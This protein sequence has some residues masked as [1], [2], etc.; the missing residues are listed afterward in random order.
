M[1][2]AII[3]FFLFVIVLLSSL[4]YF[5]LRNRVDSY[6]DSVMRTIPRSEDDDDVDKDLQKIYEEMNSSSLSGASGSGRQKER[7]LSCPLTLNKFSSTIF[8]SIACLEDPEII[9][10]VV[11]LFISA[12]YSH[13]LAVGIYYQGDKLDICNHPELQPYSSQIQAHYVPFENAKGPC[14]ARRQIESFMYRKQDLFLQIDS[15]SR[16]ARGWDVI[17]IEELLKCKNPIM[18]ILSAYPEV[19]DTEAYLL[20]TAPRSPVDAQSRS[21]TDSDMIVPKWSMMPT[22]QKC[23]GFDQGTEMPMFMSQVFF[24]RPSTPVPQLCWSGCFSFTTREV[25][26]KVPYLTGVPFAFFGEE[27]IMFARYIS[28]GCSVLTPT[29]LPLLTRFNRYGRRSFK[30][31]LHLSNNRVLHESSTKKLHKVIGGRGTNGLGDYGDGPNSLGHD[32]KL[33]LY[34]QRIGIRVRSQSILRRAALGL[35][36]FTGAKMEREA[37]DKYGSMERVV[38]LYDNLPTQLL[39]RTRKGKIVETFTG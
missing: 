38:A 20:N 23:V 32:F 36:R 31:L 8:V 34:L 21:W 33:Q 3:L 39:S 5:W 15:H 30:E 12:T 4:V 7:M 29:R 37:I 22:F 2:I 14:F 35:T 17:L 25:I 6:A 16:F 11:S 19:F 28:N 10:T 9:P 1:R 24:N 13:R 27:F 26:A 18:S